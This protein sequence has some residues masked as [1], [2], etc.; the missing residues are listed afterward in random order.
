MRALNRSLS[1]ALARMQTHIVTDSVL[2]T[3][4]SCCRIKETEANDAGKASES[5]DEDLIRMTWSRCDLAGQG[6]PRG[7][8]RAVA[9]DMQLRRQA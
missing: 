8:T 7:V 1:N 4:I 2:L 5:S 6:I 3:N 9:C